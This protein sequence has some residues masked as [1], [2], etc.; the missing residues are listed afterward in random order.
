[1]RQSEKICSIMDPD[2]MGSL[3]PD[4]N[5]ELR[6]GSRR[7]KMARKHRKK[8]LNFIFKVLGVVF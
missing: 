7:A 6:S 3:D 1:M 4:P 5:P 8:L 2:L